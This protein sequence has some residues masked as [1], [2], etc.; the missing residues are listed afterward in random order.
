[1]N[2]NQMPF[3][4]KIRSHISSIYLYKLG[5][6]SFYLKFFIYIFTN[7][8]HPLKSLFLIRKKV[9]PYKLRKNNQAI[10]TIDNE[11]QLS[12]VT[13]GIDE[14]IKIENDFMKISFQERELYFKYF[15]TIEIDIFLQKIYSLLPVKDK[16]LIDV[17]GN[18]GDS[19]LLYR[20]LGAKKV[21]MLEP[22]PKFVEFAKENIEINNESSNIQII[23]AALSN[24]KGKLFINYEKSGRSFSFEEDKDNGIE[25][26]K[27]TLNDILSNDILSND[28]LSND[29]HYVLKLDCEGCE[30][31]VLLSSPD[32][33]LQKFDG[34][35]LEFHSGFLEIA[36]R[37]EKLGFKIKILNSKFTP[38]KLYR[39]HLLA[40]RK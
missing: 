34:I 9:Y 31:D 20:V 38:K 16:I 24:R 40:V 12:L 13:R 19:S 30:Y 1:M 4:W 18:V 32:E 10:L 14:T 15:K 6:F 28:I 27:I 2:S 37:L 21:I 26:P 17:G 5:K 35:L 29:S 33:I 36:Y 8:K 11:M 22:Q 3:F 25:I 7:F 39:G 23:K